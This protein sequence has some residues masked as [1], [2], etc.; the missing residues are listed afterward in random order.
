M[1][2]LKTHQTNPTTAQFRPVPSIR[3]Q[4]RPA[5]TSSAEYSVVAPST[6]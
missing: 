6:V 3:A 2:H 1:N 4:Y 5:Q